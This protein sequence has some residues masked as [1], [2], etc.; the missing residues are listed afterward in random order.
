MNM[1]TQEA[2]ALAHGLDIRG[3]SGAGSSYGIP[4]PQGSPMGFSPPPGLG[5]DANDHVRMSQTG[6]S[7]EMSV[8]EV[9]GEGMGC[10]EGSRV[11]GVLEGVRKE[12]LYE[13][14]EG[15]VL[16]YVEPINALALRTGGDWELDKTWATWDNLQ[17]VL[18]K[19][20]YNWEVASD[21]LF[22]L[23]LSRNEGPTP[24][25]ASIE[26]RWELANFLLGMGAQYEHLAKS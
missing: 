19:L 6:L 21:P 14:V 20:A 1:N 11:E 12:F 2:H 22:Q 26:H 24:S 8:M 25:N 15:H 13:L 7:Q 3:F 17:K 4:V 18:K 16:Q 23:G 9:S 10:V 5:V